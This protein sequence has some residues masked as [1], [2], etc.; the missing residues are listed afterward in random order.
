MKILVTG[1]NGYIGSKIV[2]KLC[3]KNIEV[4]ATDF[5]NEHIDSRAKYVF[6]DI[7]SNEPNWYTFF[8]EPD[9]CLH[10]A[11]RDGFVHNSNRHM[12]DLSS[13]YNFIT[14]L[15]DNG[16]KH[17]SSMGSMHEVGYWV[18]AIDENTPC[19]PLSQYAVAKNA[20]R[21]SIE[22]YASQHKCIFQWLRGFYIYGDDSFG[23]SIFCKLRNAA[24]RREKEFPFTLGKNQYDFLNINE[25]V[26]QVIMCITQE[27]VN[28]II[29]CCSGKPVALADKVESYIKDNHLDIKLKYGAFPDREYDSPCIYGDDKKIKQIISNHNKKIKILVTGVKGQLGYDVVRELTERGYTN[30]LGI[31][32]D[33]LDITDKVAVYRFINDYRPDVVFHNAAWTAVDKAEQ[34]PDVVYAVNALGP[35]Y[36]AEA[37]KEVN[38]KMMYISTDYVFDGKGDNFFEVNDKKNGLSVYGLSKSQGEDFVTSILDKYFIIRTSWVFGINGDNFIKTMLKLANSGRAELNVVCD[39]I[40]SPTYSYD[41]SKLMCDMIATEKYGIYHATNEG[42]CSWAEFAREIFKLANKNVKVNFITTEEYRKIVPAQAY[43]PLNSRLSK[44]SLDKAG[45]IRLPTWQD[46]TKRYIDVLMED[47]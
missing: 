1:A 25:L 43:R 15:I 34:M 11:W 18:G 39:Q 23:N 6:A 38:A 47:K 24:E 19:N 12:G 45:F 3:D 2:K 7:F 13:H 16:L 14:N 17:F 22:I 33:E 41:L 4:I 5:K 44:D 40:G 35:K 27:E 20:L 30:I 37:C 46:A 26:E 31:D 28:G 21:K 10:L 8:G 32:K 29:N 36:I 9:V 42:V